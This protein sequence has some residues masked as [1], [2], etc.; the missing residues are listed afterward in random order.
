MTKS[1]RQVLRTTCATHG[2]IHVHELAV[3][4]LLI[5]IQ[6]EFATGDYAMGRIVTLYGLLF[7]LGS[8][9][10][11]WLVDRL[12]SRLLLV[13]C[14]WGSSLSLVGMALAPELTTFAV[15]A[16]AMGLCLS[17]YHP[18]GTALL[19]HAIP[20]SGRVFAYHGMAGNLG[21]AG[22]SL[23]A[24]A[25][26]W[27]FGWRWALA[28][29]ALPGILLGL[30]VMRLTD[31]PVHEIREREGTGRWPD[32]VLLLVAIAFMGMVYRGMTT[33]LPKFMTTI[34]AGQT[35][36]GVAL[37]GGLATAALLV[38]LLGMYTSGRIADSGVHASWTFLVGALFQ[39]PFLIAVGWTSGNFA[40]PLIM[41]V[42][43]F[44]FFTQPAGNQLVAGFTPPRMRGL[45]Y[46]IYFFL[47]FGVGAVG[48]TI[49]GWV[50]EELGLARAFPALA[51][52]LVPSVL[53]TLALVAR[54]R[55]RP[56][57][58]SPQ[59]VEL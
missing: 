36:F 28:L 1:Q 48:A 35:D 10:A 6:A 40:L 4:P 38:G 52:L 3:P 19:S 53:V 47:S 58:E 57:P 51:V 16:A 29:L 50:S 59:P 45:G 55:A 44:H 26:G 20:V 30:R 15:A 17:I 8:L 14:L 43:F 22:A 5:L 18:A 11:G 12:G 31:A 46:G 42:S 56:G 25:L 34:Y 2:L 13:V 39:A 9:P 49:G 33:F 41:G 27:A 23:V 21:V 32:F 54:N 24:G 37:G 7:G